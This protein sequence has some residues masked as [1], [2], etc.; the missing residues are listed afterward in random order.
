M[1]LS[2][3]YEAALVMATQLHATQKR[4]G[5][6]IPYIIEDDDIEQL[7]TTLEDAIEDVVDKISGQ[8]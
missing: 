8:V 5:T 7:V 1:Q 4:K 3:K 6:N 2:P